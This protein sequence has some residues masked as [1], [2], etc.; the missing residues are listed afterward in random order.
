[1]SSFYSFKQ[2]LP[3][4]TPDYQV[5]KQ[6]FNKFYDGYNYLELCNDDILAKDRLDDLKMV[7]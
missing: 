1:M 4:S 3:R 5:L 2:L 6:F 7:N